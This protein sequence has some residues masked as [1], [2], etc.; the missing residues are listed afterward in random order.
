MQ[1]NKFRKFKRADTRADTHAF[2]EDQVTETA[3]PLIEGEV[4]DAKCVSGTI[5]FTNLDYDTL[6]PGNPDFY[7]EARPE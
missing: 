3:I 7:Y 5:P 4:I 1:H 2:K 6:V